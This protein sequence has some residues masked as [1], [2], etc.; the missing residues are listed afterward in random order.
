MRV[1]NQLN[2]FLERFTRLARNTQLMLRDWIYRDLG[3]ESEFIDRK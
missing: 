3:A 1:H 2:T